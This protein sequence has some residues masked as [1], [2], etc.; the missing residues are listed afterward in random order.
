MWEKKLHNCLIRE[1]K[2][3]YD[4]DGDVNVTSLYFE[5]WKTVGFHALH[6]DFPLLYI[7]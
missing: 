7:S 5:W 1:V 2:Q 4:A 3:R 6:V